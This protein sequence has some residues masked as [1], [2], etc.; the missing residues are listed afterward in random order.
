MNPAVRPASQSQR[1]PSSVPVSS[2]WNAVKA[3][4]EK[5]EE[6]GLDARAFAGLKVA[7]VGDATSR[8][9]VEFG[10]KPDL[11]VAFPAQSGPPPAG[12][13][14]DGVWYRLDFT[15]RIATAQV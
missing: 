14:V 11:V 7:A 1:R 10:V 6:Y 13:V 12:R 9:L 8:A 5:F 4:R 2:L 15:F 3:V